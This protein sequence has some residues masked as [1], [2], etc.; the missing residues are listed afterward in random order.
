LVAAKGRDVLPDI[1]LSNMGKSQPQNE[2]CKSLIALKISQ[3]KQFGEVGDPVKTK[4]LAGW[5]RNPAN[6]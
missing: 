1:S 5:G 3:A 2:F 4:K 6:R